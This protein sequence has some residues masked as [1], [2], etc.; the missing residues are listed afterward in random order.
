MIRLDARHR[1]IVC[2]D[3]IQWIV[4]RRRGQR[5]GRARWAALGYCTTRKAL[6]RVCHSSC[7]VLDPKALASLEALPERIG[8]GT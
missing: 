7:G 8:G 5:C 2:K 3:G 6:I 4:Q 1:V